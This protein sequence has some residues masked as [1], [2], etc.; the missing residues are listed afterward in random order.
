MKAKVKVA[1]KYVK[2]TVCFVTA[3][4]VALDRMEG[5]HGIHI[6]DTRMVLYCI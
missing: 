5:K 4:N 3:E 6:D 1:T 2:M